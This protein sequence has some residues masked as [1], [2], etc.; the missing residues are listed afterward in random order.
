[1]LKTA[2]AVRGEGVGLIG[3]WFN[4]A[5]GVGGRL[6]VVVAGE[7]GVLGED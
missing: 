1:V 6:G 4:E 2:R 7:A 3:S 5:G